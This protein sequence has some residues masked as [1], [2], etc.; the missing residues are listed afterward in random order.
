M[1]E[2]IVSQLTGQDDIFLRALSRADVA[3][4]ERK[5][6]ALRAKAD[7][8]RRRG[9]E[10]AR[11]R[12]LLTKLRTQAEGASHRQ[13]CAS[14]GQTRSL[15]CLDHQGILFLLLMLLV[16]SHRAWLCCMLLTLT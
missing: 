15:G 13:V 4:L 16:I 14:G 12:D 11:E 10:L 2:H 8:E 7:A 3:A 6:E 5:A 1:L 9:E